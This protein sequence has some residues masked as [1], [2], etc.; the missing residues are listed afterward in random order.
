MNKFF[1]D[2][3]PYRTYIGISLI[4]VEH[5]VLENYYLG[6]L[7]KK[8]PNAQNTKQYELLVVVEL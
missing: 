4:L 2:F 3:K 5:I 8:S 7:L 1:L 6:I